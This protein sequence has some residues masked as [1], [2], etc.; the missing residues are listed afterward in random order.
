MRFPGHTSEMSLVRIDIDEEALAEVM[1][2]MA[3]SSEND[4]INTLLREYVDHANR[5]E[6][7]E[8]RASLLLARR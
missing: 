6:A 1:R 8:R 2:L 3:T 5:L 4:A 7:A